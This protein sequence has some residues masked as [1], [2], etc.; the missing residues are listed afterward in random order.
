MQ[1]G[2]FEVDEK[3]KVLARSVEILLPNQTGPT[4]TG[5]GQEA[6]SQF[7]QQI[8]QNSALSRR[9]RRPGSVM[10]TATDRLTGA[11]IRT[12]APLHKL[13][14]SIRATCMRLPWRRGTPT[15]L[16]FFLHAAKNRPTSPRSRPRR[17][18]QTYFVFRRGRER[19]VQK[20]F[21]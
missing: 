18:S 20:S 4:H 17:L 6:C 3:R 19:G 7:S 21:L 11:S 16:H 2:P 1:I 10:N 12:P 14:G 8:N 13:F 5:N 9:R 15:T